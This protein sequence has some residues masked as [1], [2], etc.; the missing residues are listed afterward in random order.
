MGEKLLTTRE[1]SKILRISEKELID[2]TKAGKVPHFKIAGEFLRFKK[3]DVN[4]LKKEVEEEFNIEKEKVPIKQRL[5][6]F[7]YFNDFYILSSIVIAIL[8]VLVF[9]G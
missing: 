6:D 3:E 7:F 1:A 2:L 8:L 4:Y 9:K 5:G